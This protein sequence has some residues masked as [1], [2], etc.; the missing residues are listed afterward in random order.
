M[1]SRVRSATPS[2]RSTTSTHARRVLA[3]TGVRAGP[4]GS[5]GSAGG[6]LST[7]ASASAIALGDVRP[8]HDHPSREL[9]LLASDVL[10][11]DPEL[12]DEGRDRSTVLVV[13]EAQR[14]LVDLLLGLPISRLE[15]LRE[16]VVELGV[17]QL[18]LVPGRLGGIGDREDLVRMSA[19]VVR[20]VHRFHEPHLVPVRVRRALVDLHAD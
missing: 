19:R 3:G 8:L 17:L 12:A 11:L 2:W 9:E 10:L 1:T 6:E 14:V 15:S 13:H 20:D 7:G 5:A 16:E 18:A 4:G